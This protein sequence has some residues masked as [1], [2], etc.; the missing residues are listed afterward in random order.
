MC[1][2]ISPLRKQ[3]PQWPEFQHRG[4]SRSKSVS[5]PH[6]TRAL[7]LARVRA[8]PPLSDGPDLINAPWKGVAGV[9]GLIAE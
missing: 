7:F 5:C 6:I 9:R 3:W 2:L 4:P 1:L 8:T